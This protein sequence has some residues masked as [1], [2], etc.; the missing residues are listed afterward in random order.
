MKKRVLVGLVVIAVAIQL[1]PAGSHESQPG[2]G[3]IRAPS[4]VL[5]ILRR[6]CYDCH[7]NETRWPWYSY[8]APVSWLLAHH[9]G[10]ARHHMDF[11]SWSDLQPQDRQHLAKEIVEHV[12]KGVMPLPLYARMHSDARV[13]E[14]ELNVL[15]SW[16]DDLS[17]R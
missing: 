1:Y 9:V 17:G 2:T 10:E 6:S 14:T 5:A 11:S 4:E 15:R 13:S 7:S 12:E 16:K 3:E 8:V